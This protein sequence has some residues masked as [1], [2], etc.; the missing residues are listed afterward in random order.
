MLLSSL[1]KVVMAS[2][3][4]GSSIAQ[5]V[6][7]DQPVI[8]VQEKEV[9]TLDCIYDTNDFTYSL[10][11]YKQPSS[12]AM[13]LLIRQDSYNQQNATEGR[14]SLNF[15]KANKSIKLAISASQ[16]E[17]S[18]VYFCALS[19]PTVRGVLEAGQTREDSVTQ[20]DGQMTLPEGAALTIN[21]TYS[22]TGYPTTFWYVQYPGEGPQVLLKAMK[23]NEKGTNKEFEATYHKESKSFHLEKASVQDSDSAVYYCALSDTVMGTAGAAEHKLFEWQQG[24][25]RLSVSPFDPLCG[26]VYGGLSLSL[27]LIQNS[28]K[29][30]E[31]KNKK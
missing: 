10:Y 25:W 19:E 5:K 11:W 3:W 7:Q 23:D 15:Q 12:G 26:T 8:L 4:L 6:T 1:L 2:L 27:W 9:V 13:I 17:D 29:F 21:C 20:M 28:Y 24:A 22:A 16:L 14:Y 30:L 18:A 31:N